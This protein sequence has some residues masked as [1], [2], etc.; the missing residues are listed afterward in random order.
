MRYGSQ[1]RVG[2][3]GYEKGRIELL[4]VHAVEKRVPAAV[5]MAVLEFESPVRDGLAAA[6]LIGVTAVVRV[7]DD[8]VRQQYDIVPVGFVVG[9]KRLDPV[10]PERLIG[11]EGPAR[12]VCI[13]D[14][15]VAL[16]SCVESVTEPGLLAADKGVFIRGTGQVFRNEVPAVGVRAV[17]AERGYDELL[18]GVRRALVGVGRSR[19]RREPFAIAVKHDCGTDLFEV[20]DAGGRLR[21]ASGLVQRG[22]QHGGENRN[23]CDHDYDHLLNIQYGVY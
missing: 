13:G 21:L 18:P 23:D 12:I 1:Q 20:V 7:R 17:A 19:T 9:V 8:A 11:G 2:I 6:V 4:D 14:F 5:R 3:A 22:Q 15:A 16:A 10:H